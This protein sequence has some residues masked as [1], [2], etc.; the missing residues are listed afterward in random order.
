MTK[1]VLVLGANGR[2][3]RAAVL[4][5][6][7]AGWQVR[8]QLRR[9]PRAALPAGVQLVQCDALDVPALT[10]AG[11]GAQVI[12]HALNPDYTRWATLLPPQTAAVLAVARATGATLMLPGNVY[13]FGHQ[14]PAVLTEDTPFVANHPKAAQRI[15]LEAALAE[16]AASGVRSIVLRAGDFLGDAGTWIDLAMAKDLARGRF[17]HMGPADLPHAWAWLPDLAQTFVAVAERRASL[18]PHAVLHVPGLTLTGAQLQRAFEA[19]LGRPLRAR[20]F[21]WPLLRL[22]APFWPMGR[23]LVEMRHLWQRPHQLDG[24][25]LR[26]LLG[27]DLPQ[28][29]LDSVVRQCLAGLPQPP[30]LPAL[31]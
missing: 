26:A 15:A 23:A 22:A 20:R 10:A 16:A 11:Q 25:R 12:V 17:T 6:A 24:T 30:G 19:A 8:A 14:L 31:A 29:P 7:A 28:T 13:N 9:A 3:G 4:A 2:L 5:F 21:P 27:G 1:T 18:P